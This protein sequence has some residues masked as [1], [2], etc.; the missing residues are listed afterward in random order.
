[1][2]KALRHWNKRMQPMLLNFSIA[3]L[4]EKAPSKLKKKAGAGKSGTREAKRARMAPARQK[5]LHPPSRPEEKIPPGTQHPA[6]SPG[7]TQSSPK[8][9]KNPRAKGKSLL[10]FLS[11]L[12][13]L[14]KKKKEPSARVQ[15]ETGK[16]QEKHGAEPEKEKGK[17]N[18][19]RKTPLMKKSK[20][21]GMQPA[22]AKP[23]K[24]KIYG[25]KSKKRG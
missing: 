12:P 20:N 7:K 10:S 3:D 1:M 19:G 5:P 18:R 17:E 14:G 4:G 9:E 22:D 23:R 16:K 8:L 2:G 24:K 6:G 21:Y 11:S 13:F 25:K 15:E